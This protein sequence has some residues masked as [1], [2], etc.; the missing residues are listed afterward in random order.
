[1]EG[2]GFPAT[3]H[4]S[5]TLGPSCSVCCEKV[6]WNTG[7]NEPETII[8]SLFNALEIIDNQLAKF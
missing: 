2:G 8:R 1:M 6:W 5:D 7:G 3:S 4:L